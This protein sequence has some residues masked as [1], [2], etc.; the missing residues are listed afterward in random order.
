MLKA[1]MWWR[2]IKLTIR[3]E[4]PEEGEPLPF[5]VNMFFN[6]VVITLDMPP[7]MVGESY[8]HIISKG[9]LLR[10]GVEPGDEIRFSLVPKD[11]PYGVAVDILTYEPVP[12][13]VDW[14]IVGVPAT[15]GGAIGYASKPKEP[16]IPALAG[17][18]LGTVAGAIIELLISALGGQ[19]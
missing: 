19:G 5:L 10:W 3:H 2:S 16:V 9:N 6:D 18:G 12:E 13:W 4:Y 1:E 15:V 11:K 14:A 7:L 17:A 8:V